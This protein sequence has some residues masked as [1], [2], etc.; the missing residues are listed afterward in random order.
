MPD[1]NKYVYFALERNSNAAYSFTG[2]TNPETGLVEAIYKG[3]KD[4]N[5][6]IDIPH[7]FRFD[8]SH[9]SIRVGKNEKDI[10]GNSV[11][12]F[13]RKF[14]ECK[15]SVYGSYHGEGKDRAQTNVWFREVNDGKDAQISV[16]AKTAKI[17]AENTALELEG[18]DLKEMAMLCGEF[19]DDEGLQKHR[20]LEFAG[21]DP[22]SFMKL[23]NSP[24]R[25]AK[26][27]LTRALRAG[28]IIQKGTL[29]IWEEVTVGTNELNAISK[30]MEDKALAG[31]IED[32]LKALGK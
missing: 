8:R 13:L 29:Y 12:E 25:S 6:G 11:V 9:R 28:L 3:R 15:D 10:N 31:A 17:K 1:F 16:E 4:P 19:R 2:F 7:R 32:N 26:V 14:P 20:V 23:H 5:T 18:N 24:E 22:E 21:A 30:L 27:L